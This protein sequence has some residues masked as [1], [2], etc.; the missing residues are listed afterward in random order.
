MD[1]QKDFEKG[2][3]EYKAKRKREIEEMIGIIQGV[4]GGCA[5][6]WAKLIAEELHKNRYRKSPENAVVLTR[7]E[8]KAINL[9]NAVDMLREIQRQARKETAEKFAKRLKEALGEFFDDSEDNDG[10]ISKAICLIEIIGVV[11]KNGE[12]ISLGLID[13]ICKEIT[14]GIESVS[15]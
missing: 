12:V 10:K 13:E 4:V 3:E 14:E 6:H 2:F 1:K 7:E 15:R 11:A 9:D 5:E 8:Y